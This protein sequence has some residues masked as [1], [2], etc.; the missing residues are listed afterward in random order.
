MSRRFSVLA[1]LVL[2]A[3]SG[4]PAADGAAIATIGR[5]AETALR[6]DA[7][8]EPCPSL[9]LAARI[10][11][12]T[13]PPTGSVDLVFVLVTRSGVQPLGR[14]GIFPQAPFST[15]RGDQP[16]SF[17]FRVDRVADPNARLRLSLEPSEGDG[18][19][20]RAELGE[21]RLAPAGEIGC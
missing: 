4:A 3:C 7:A 13:P 14:V 12:Y 15:A 11:G 19:G 6:R 20:A 18:H 9:R 17:A 2:A 5:P 10:D 16:H 8:A 21:A 1:F